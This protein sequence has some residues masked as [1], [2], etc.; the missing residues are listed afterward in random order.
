MKDRKLYQLILGI[1][2][3]LLLLWLFSTK[4]KFTVAST[5]G[6]PW[7]ALK[8]EWQSY[9]DEFANNSNA[10]LQKM[11][12]DYAKAMLDYKEVPNCI[13]VLRQV[14][15]G[16]SLFLRTFFQTQ[17]G[18]NLQNAIRLICTDNSVKQHLRPIANTK[19]ILIIYFKDVIAR[20]TYSLS[21]IEIYNNPLDP[22]IKIPSNEE[23][24]KKALDFGNS[25]PQINPKLIN[26]LK[27]SLI[28]LLKTEIGKQY[29]QFLNIHATTYA[30]FNSI[31]NN[32][33]PN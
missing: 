29:L 26:A 33:I 22:R 11:A 2:F 19:D 1:T 21:Y 7:E 32:V 12:N 14:E 9:A 4:E 23:I 27:V 25:I 24:Q 16:F 5:S 17:R 30:N 8:V 13:S 6:V 18:K 31:L 28:T 20:G 10:K 3:I 15:N